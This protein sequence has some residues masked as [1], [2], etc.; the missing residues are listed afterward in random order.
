V[1]VAAPAFTDPRL[2][3]VADEADVAVARGEPRRQLAALVDALAARAPAGEVQES[4]AAAAGALVND[5]TRARVERVLA[6]S[7]LGDVEGDLGT[8]AEPGPVA[9]A[10]AYRA[11]LPLLARDERVQAPLKE[12]EISF[13][14]FD[15][16]DRQRFGPVL[17][18][19]ATPALGVDI[20]LMKDEGYSFVA[21]YPP[22]GS[23]GV[24]IVGKAAR[25]LTRRMT[26]DGDAPR[27]AMRRFLALLAE[28]VEV[29]LP[30]ASATIDRLLEEPVPDAPAQ[31]RLFV[32]LARG[33]VE[34]A[35]AERGFPF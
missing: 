6:E 34:E 13:A 19:A 22:E 31:D 2:L 33:L 20:A 10:L 17:A 26:M 28:E 27:T 32:A 16:E 35:V 21:I 3:A 14:E 9:L 29:D 30:V 4:L 12:L 25:W 5:D 7:D 8:S 18:R 15:D 1:S 23:E 24:D 11:A